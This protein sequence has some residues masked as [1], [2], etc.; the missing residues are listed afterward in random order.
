MPIVVSVVFS[1]F[2]DC[3][4]EV[5]LLAVENMKISEHFGMD[6]SF[7]NHRPGVSGEFKAH[8]DDFV[9]EERLGF[10]PAGFGEHLFVKIT[11]RDANT[12]YVAQRLARCV[13]VRLRDI[14]FAGRKDRHAVASQWF[15]CW[16][17]GRADPPVSQ[18]QSQF[19]ES[20]ID[21]ETSVRHTRKLRKGGHLSNSFTI[22]IRKL[23]CSSHAQMDATREERLELSLAKVRQLG[24]PNYFGLQRFGRNSGNLTAVRGLFTAESLAGELH[25]RN[26]GRRGLYLSAARAYLFNRI[27]SGRVAAGTWRELRPDGRIGTGPLYGIG[28][29]LNDEERACIDGFTDLAAGL[30]NLGVKAGRR[31]L[32]VM[33]QNLQS[34]I[35]DDCLILAFTL[36][37]GAFATS[38]LRELV[39]VYEPARGLIDEVD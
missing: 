26:R 23:A 29:Q 13:G 3:L 21:V 36:P 15:S 6:F 8:A 32:F 16:L 31:P 34:S 22:R 9:V 2:S 24:V 25:T 17:P 14:G 4:S 19:Q 35:E 18:L 27:L 33:P 37:K 11:K 5:A 20:G 7:A 10:S 12:A 1:P 39:S 30:E 28:T 38:V